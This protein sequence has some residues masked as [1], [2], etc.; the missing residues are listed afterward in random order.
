VT[1]KLLLIDDAPIL[2]GAELFGLRLAR[3]LQRER[4]DR[5]T[6][7]IACPAGSALAV[8]CA[9][10]SIP[11]HA[12]AFPDLG[13]RGVPGMPPAVRAVARLLRD[14]ARTDALVVATTA[15]AQAYTAAAQ[16]VTRGGAPFVNLLLEQDT[17]ARPSARFVLRRTGRLVAIGENTAAAYGAALPG[18][19]VGRL[20][21]FLDPRAF[22]AE[23]PA[24]GPRPDGAA[25]ALGLLA[26]VIPEKG[27]L[28]LIE[29]LARCPSSWSTL[30]VVGDEQDAPYAARV[31]ARIGELG[32]GDR[33]ILKGFVS[34]IEAFLSEIDAL[35]VP[36]V[37]NE[38]QPTVI[39]EGLAHGLPVI[40]RRPI[41]SRDFEGLPVLPYTDPGELADAI[42]RSRELG[43]APADELERRFG[44]EQ[45]LDALIAAGS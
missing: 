32:L 22:R 37:G 33:V 39:V 13:P 35:V 43:P 5:W 9:Q 45:A 7:E 17:A 2:G 23:R 42:A 41:W 18:M 44:P 30:V 6:T 36:S 8:R 34:E 10:E 26:R 31:R 28:D 38:G 25:P 14:A 24:R 19:H 40:V 29:E 4:P 21:N 1:R 11:V 16:L 20:N 12:A 3:W 27:V 15:R